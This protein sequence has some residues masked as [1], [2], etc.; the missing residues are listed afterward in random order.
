[1]RIAFLVLVLA[2]LALFAGSRWLSPQ[3]SGGVAAAGAATAGVAA[4][5]RILLASERDAAA[6]KAD[7]ATVD[8]TAPPVAGVVPAGAGVT[9]AAFVVA[10]STAEAP[11]VAEADLRRC[12]SMGPFT[13]LDAAAEAAALLKQDGY[14][15]RQ[16][17]AGG[18]VPDGYMV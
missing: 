8:G 4:P 3:E 11:A 16:R 14:E 13:G 9:E 6:P 18:P 1:M 7:P 12:V 2:N 5:A 17:P 10:G 15:P